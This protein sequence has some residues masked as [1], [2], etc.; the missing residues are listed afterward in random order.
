VLDFG[1]AKLTGTQRPLILPDVETLSSHDTLP[2]IVVG[3]VRYMSPEQAQ[4]LKVDSRSDIFSLG[5]V[6]YEMITGKPPFDGASTSDVVVAIVEKY[7]PP[8][9]NFVNI[10]EEVQWIVT[11]ALAKN[12]NERYQTAKDLLTDLKRLRKQLEIQE[13]LRRSDPYVTHTSQSLK[14]TSL[15]KASKPLKVAAWL[16]GMGALLVILIAIVYSFTRPAARRIVPVPEYHR[17]TFSGKAS[18]PSI[19]PDGKLIAYTSGSSLIV[20]D[21]AG[22]QPFELYK[23][24]NS[25]LD[26]AQPRW[27]PD[28][29]QIAFTIRGENERGVYV[30]N[31]LGGT[32]RRIAP[33]IYYPAWSTDGKQ[34][35]LCYQASKEIIFKDLLTGDTKSIPLRGGFTWIRDLDWSSNGQLLIL[36]MDEKALTYQIWILN[37]TGSE[38]KKVVQ[39]SD[40]ITSARWAPDGKAIYYFVSKENTKNLV[41]VIV[42]NKSYVNAVTKTV[43]SGLEAGEAFAVSRDGK[44][45]AYSREFSFSN[46]WIATDEN[47][48][49]SRQFKTRQLTKGT[50]SIHL[51]SFSPDGIRVA[52]S[53]GNL[54]KSNIY[55]MELSSGS[56]KQLT[57]MNSFNTSPSWSPDGKSIAF[58]S[59]DGKK[60][61]VWIVQSDGDNLR[62]FSGSKISQTMILIWYPGH[63][64]LYQLPG[65][66]NFHLLNP[67]SGT[68]T[69]L[70][71]DESRGWIFTPRFSWDGS[72]IAAF[73]NRKP[74]RGLFTISLIDSKEELLKEGSFDPIGWSTDG[75]WVY[76][77]D[78]ELKLSKVSTLDGKT[79][80][81]PDLPFK[82][83]LPATEVEIDINN[84]EQ[85]FVINV[86]EK[87][88]DL[89]IVENFD[90]EIAPQL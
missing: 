24:E 78:E 81:L 39:D 88:P 22:G 35:A 66:R 12:T 75:D 55:V 10:P 41:K 27:S 9:R 87:Y 73:W 69:L 14:S 18:Q 77:I 13:E 56:I 83:K 90:P 79:V 11:K 67:E 42:E 57:F 72:K 25:H 89:W 52:F 30:I 4:G 50:S 45:L 21:A 51:P 19:S 65:N 70:L 15:L 16:T 17:I 86:P 3:T 36:T 59:S 26:N 74:S 76:V 8:L 80:H 44:Q 5:V 32:L 63:Q 68:E 34:I 64:I 31:R 49:G 85:S 53:M 43:L 58:A 61:S 84:D 47:I 82:D 46:L 1:L 20:Q 48:P 37:A 54:T 28:G 7:P 40:E 23:N 62:E 38:H 6:L 33:Q 2:G 60:R 29:S 71:K